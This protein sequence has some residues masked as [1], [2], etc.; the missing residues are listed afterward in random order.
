[1]TLIT[2][3]VA[4]FDVQFLN[5]QDIPPELRRRPKPEFG[6][7]IFFSPDWEREVLRFHEKQRVPTV[8]AK[9]IIAKPKFLM[10]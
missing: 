10:K 1:M 2:R 5:L 3:I 6:G 9:S 4:N 8:L 7:L